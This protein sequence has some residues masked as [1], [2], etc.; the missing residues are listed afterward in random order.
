MGNC[1]E[2]DFKIESGKR[3]A[4]EALMIAGANN[5]TNGH[6]V[7]AGFLNKTKERTIKKEELPYS[8]T[9]TDYA[10][11]S[12]TT[13][14]VSKIISNND[15]QEI[16]TKVGYEIIMNSNLDVLKINI[17]SKNENYSFENIPIPKELFLDEHPE[18][19]FLHF[20]DRRLDIIELYIKI[21]ENSGI[22]EFLKQ[23]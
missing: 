16:S 4:K 13:I 12:H 17:Y 6:I 8:F 18:E 20:L 1:I 11:E 3:I 21:G 5:T 14:S 19:T 10:G 2:K 15:L 7:K 23:D 9:F 22:T